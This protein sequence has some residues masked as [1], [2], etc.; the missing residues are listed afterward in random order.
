MHSEAE[1]FAANALVRPSSGSPHVQARSA[2]S[3]ALCSAGRG[4][5]ANHLTCAPSR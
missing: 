5:A 2:A 3:R 1:V 4:L